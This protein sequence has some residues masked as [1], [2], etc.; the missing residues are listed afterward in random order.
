MSGVVFG[1][2]ARYAPVGVAPAGRWDGVENRVVTKRESVCASDEV[3]SLSG[4]LAIRVGGIERPLR[5][6]YNE[7]ALMALDAEVEVLALMK[8]ASMEEQHL[9]HSTTSWRP[10]SDRERLARHHCQL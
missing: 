5:R 9:L 2:E 3:S 1:L 4:D 6:G 10:S 8:I 7:T